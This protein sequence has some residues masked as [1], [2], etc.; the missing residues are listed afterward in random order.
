MHAFPKDCQ[1][2]HGCGAILARL[3]MSSR[4]EQQ[5]PASLADGHLFAVLLIGE[6]LALRSLIAGTL[7]APGMNIVA[8]VW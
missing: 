1:R 4:L 5:P 7:S 2:W 6:G 3:E 8:G